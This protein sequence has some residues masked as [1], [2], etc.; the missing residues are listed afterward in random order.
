VF[1]NFVAPRTIARGIDLGNT[2]DLRLETLADRI[3]SWR[4]IVRVAY[5]KPARFILL[6]VRIIRVFI[7]EYSNLSC[8]FRVSLNRIREEFLRFNFPHISF[9]IYVYSFASINLALQL[10]PMLIQVNPST[11]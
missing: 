11:A 8:A 2:R 3:Q 9:H 4:N 7:R 10:S 5:T 6:H 1:A